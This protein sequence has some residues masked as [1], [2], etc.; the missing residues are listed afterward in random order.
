MPLKLHTIVHLKSLGVFL[1]NCD[2][3]ETNLGQN[4]NIKTTGKLGS[5]GFLNKVLVERLKIEP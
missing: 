1:N 4:I 5:K 3:E 2:F